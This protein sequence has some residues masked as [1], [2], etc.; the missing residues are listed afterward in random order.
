VVGKLYGIGVGP[1]DP[2]LI[3]LK[4]LRLLQ[5]VPVV[6]FPAGVRGQPGIAQR[7]VTERLQAHQMQLALAF[8]YV[9]DGAV[10][11]DAWQGSRCGFCLRG[12]CEFL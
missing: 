9:Q 1:G 7:I 11:L 5:S 8:P 2:E 6:A 4:G 10:L 3:T 12:R